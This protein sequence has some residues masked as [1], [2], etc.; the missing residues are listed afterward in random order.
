MEDYYKGLNF[1]KLLTII[2]DDSHSRPHWRVK[3]SGGRLLKDGP[4][5]LHRK[6]PTSKSCV[7]ALAPVC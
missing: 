5:T 1:L 4:K 3:G 6:Y 2:D 7:E